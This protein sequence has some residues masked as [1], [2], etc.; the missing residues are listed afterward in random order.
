[1]RRVV[2]HRVVTFLRRAIPVQRLRLRSRRRVKR[3]R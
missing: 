3:V 2:P 1:M